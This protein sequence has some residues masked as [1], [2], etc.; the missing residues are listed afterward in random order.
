MSTTTAL[1]LKTRPEW[2]PHELLKI[3]SSS[4]SE[5]FMVLAAKKNIKLCINVNTL[6]IHAMNVFF[7]GLHTARQIFSFSS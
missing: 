6:L 7:I 3:Q 1:L 4:K 2:S 5:N